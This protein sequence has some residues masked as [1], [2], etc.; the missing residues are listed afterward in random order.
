[1][2]LAGRGGGSG[3][4]ARLTVESGA[5]PGR[6][7]SIPAGDG[8]GAASSGPGRGDSGDSR[9]ARG[10]AGGPRAPRGSARAAPA[11]RVRR[12]LVRK[13]RSRW[14]RRPQ[15]QFR[16]LRDGTIRRAGPPATVRTS[17]ATPARPRFRTAAEG[18]GGTRVGL[19]A[20]VYWRVPRPAQGPSEPILSPGAEGPAAPGSAGGGGGGVSE[21]TR[22]WA[23]TVSLA[24][25]GC[26]REFTGGR[27]RAPQR[28]RRIPGYRS[29][30]PA[31][32]CPNRRVPLVD[33]QGRHQD[34]EREKRG[35]PDPGLAAQPEHP[36][37]GRR[38]RFGRCM[39]VRGGSCI[40][41]SP[42]AGSPSP[43]AVSVPVPGWF[44]Q[45][46]NLLGRSGDRRFGGTGGPA[47]FGHRSATLN[48]ALRARGLAAILGR[49]RHGF[50][51]QDGEPR[52]VAERMLDPAVFQRME[53][54]DGGSAA[55]FEPVGETGEGVVEVA[56]LVV[57][58]DPE[59]L[60]GPGRRV[61]RAPLAGHAL[62]DDLG[63]PGGRRDRLD[64][65]RLDDPPGDP[66]AVPFLAILED[67]PGQF[68]LVQ[69]LTR[70]AAVGRASG[71]NRMSSGPSAAKL[72][73]R[74]AQASWSDERPRSSK[75]PST[76]SIPSSSRT[77]PRSL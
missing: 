31:S 21:A 74:C 6:R 27:G 37:R 8:S 19:V 24:L 51:R 29:S 48:F 14:Q 45:R 41:A 65:P 47:R 72:N 36:A 34:Q 66:P 7:G 26:S 75:M 55:G 12:H 64:P 43:S 25:S 50:P 1:M 59:G 20:I 71:S 57:D 2:G 5:G 39:L 9:R 22:G 76:A 30:P 33:D 46:S 23:L 62:A 38:E 11:G 18:E 28:R 3:R 52:V 54:D 4:T 42:R 35:D 61:D 16:G 40:G 77:S 63:E 69:V 73:P 53:A 56:E 58:R 70:S 67:Q 60:E 32:A 49:G 44:I 13:R 10:T 68:L 15:G 17:P